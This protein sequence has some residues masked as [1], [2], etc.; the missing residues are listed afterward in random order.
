MSTYR[1]I[2]HTEG[3]G[4][5]NMAVD[6]A[7]LESHISGQC[8][9]TLRLYGFAPPAISLGYNQKASPELEQRA[10]DNGFDLVRRPTGGRAV[11]HVGELTYSFVGKSLG[12]DPEGFLEATITGAYRQI[13]QGLI[14]ALKQLSVESALGPAGTAYRHMDDCFAATTG[15]DLQ[16]GGLK[17]AGSA[18]VRR[19]G[20]VLQHGSILLDQDQGLAAE[21]LAGST[22]SGLPHHANL[23]ELA[24]REIALGELEEAMQI[25]FSQ[26]FGCRFQRQDLSQLELERTRQLCR[27]AASAQKNKKRLRR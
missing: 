2:A 7:I 11:L 5:W 18:Q 20:A 12:E 16:V 21:L 4:A 25:G 3:S 26:A 24:G 27:V 10:R 6:E 15:A 19:R 23:F 13:C 17:I 22:A 8:A 14:L 1:L 9:P